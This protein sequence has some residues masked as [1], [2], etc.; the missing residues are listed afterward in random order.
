MLIKCPIDK[1]EYDTE[2]L[3]N[4]N[5]TFQGIKVFLTILPTVENSKTAICYIDGVD[6]KGNKWRFSYEKQTTGNY[7][8]ANPNVIERNNVIIL[9]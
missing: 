1:I 3:A 8:W 2:E 7:D 4:G 6:E 9:L 5:I